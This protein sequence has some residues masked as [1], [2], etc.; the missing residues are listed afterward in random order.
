M[1]MRLE[2]KLVFQTDAPPDAQR[3]FTGLK[4]AHEIL[5]RLEVPGLLVGGLARKAW[6]GGHRGTLSGRKDVDV[7]VLSRFSEKHPS[8]FEGGIDWW[9]TDD[10]DV[11]PTNGNGCELIYTVEIRNPLAPGLHLA[12]PNFLWAWRREELSF[13]RK[14]KFGRD[15][16][17]PR[18]RPEPL[19]LEYP[20]PPERSLEWRFI[21]RDRWH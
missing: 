10:P 21:A 12:V 20:L 15:T 2:T 6:T 17:T 1:A 19:I 7:I 18:I 14:R 8:R 5:L 4:I 13:F 11:G 9:M 16:R 3:G